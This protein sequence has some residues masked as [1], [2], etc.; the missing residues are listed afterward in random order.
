VLTVLAARAK[1]D[2]VRTCRPFVIRPCSAGPQLRVRPPDVGVARVA[3]CRVEGEVFLLQNLH[4][5]GARQLSPGR[6]SSEDEPRRHI[7]AGPDRHLQV[8][9]ETGSQG[10]G[11][12]VAKGAGSGRETDTGQTRD[13]GRIKG[14]R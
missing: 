11:L 9:P 14:R 2:M 10:P 8:D 13:P 4:R 5:S 1:P 7:D 3:M 6:L 12:D